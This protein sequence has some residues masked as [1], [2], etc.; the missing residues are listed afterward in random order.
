MM[1]V[2]FLDSSSD[3]HISSISFCA[4]INPTTQCTWICNVHSLITQLIDMASKQT[5]DA[6]NRK[7][8][9]HKMLLHKDVPYKKYCTQF[10]FIAKIAVF[11]FYALNMMFMM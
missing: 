11:K 9:V 4:S 1:F 2:N 6:M 5:I 7:S 10:L 8:N 3:L